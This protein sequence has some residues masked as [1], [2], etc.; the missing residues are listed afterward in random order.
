MIKDTKG[1]N[2]PV[3]MKGH[4]NRFWKAIIEQVVANASTG[5]EWWSELD[6]QV[7]ELHILRGKHES[8]ISK[9]NDLPHEYLDAL[10]TFQHYLDEATKVLKGELYRSV[11]ASPPL[12]GLFV[13]RPPGKGPPRPSKSTQI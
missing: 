8:N 10:L 3:L 7:R 13:R 1:R 11:M 5:L 2:H 12:R 6:A 9:D 4:E